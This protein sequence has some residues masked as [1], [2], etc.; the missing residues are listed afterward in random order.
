[1]SARLNT[2][3]FFDPVGPPLLHPWR[4]VHG[5]T[6]IGQVRENNEDTFLIATM[7]REM[8]IQQ[9]S[10]TP[11][12]RAPRIDAAQGT[13]LVVADG[14]GGRGGG[15]LASAVAVDAL[16]EYMMDVMPW[17]L[18]LDRAHSDELVTEIEAALQ[19]C[20][21]SLREV[22]VRKG[23]AHERPGTTLTMAYVL[24]PLVYVVNAGDS[25]CYR[26]R[27]GELTQLTR[28][29]TLAQQ[30]YDRHL[31]DEETFRQ[32]RYRHVLSN[33]IG[34]GSEALVPEISRIELV[35]GDGLMLCSDGLS[36][37]L[38]RVEMAHILSLPGSA[39]ERCQRLIAAANVAGGRD[40]IT[41]IVAQS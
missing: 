41:V 23:L 4:D 39:A 29:H 26:I 11:A 10:L 27:A 12:Q 6:D 25:R 33:A 18:R 1:V 24:W 19:Q 30:L 16:A 40:N 32:S 28:D 34:G 7:V 3:Q 15:E 31:I 38:G 9:T 22:A 35:Q 21:R 2:L 5:A 17:L 14:V 37:E 8:R 13:V 36:N 20:Q